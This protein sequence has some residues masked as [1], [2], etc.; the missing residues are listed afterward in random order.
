MKK[1]LL[2][3]GFFSF[4]GFQL[5][6]QNDTVRLSF[7]QAVN[8][9]QSRNLRL[10][11]AEAQIQSHEF[12]RK[13]TRGLYLP[14]ISFSATYMKFDQDIGLD[15]SPLTDAYRDAFLIPASQMLPSTL[16]L[17]KE[18]MAAASVNLIWPVFN[19]GKIRA[20]NQAMD[21]NINESLYI[22]EQAKN[23]LNTE[24][25]ERYYGYR[26]AQKGVE[27]YKEVYNAMLLHREN[28]VKL[29]ENG[30]ISKAQ[31]LYTEIALSQA[32]TDYQLA[33][34]QA[35]TVKK[36]LQ[37]T[38]A[39]SSEVIVTSELFLNKNIE[40][41]EFFQQSA[42]INNALL[43][44]V[45]AKKDLVKQNHNLKKADYYP[46][47]A[48]VA[49]KEIAEHQ[50]TELMPDWFIGVNL[51]WTIFDGIS[52][53]YKVKAAKATVDRVDFIE[54]KAEADIN[55]YI[56]KLYYDLLAYKEQLETMQTTYNFAVEYLRVEQKAFAEGFATTKD[57]VDA[58]TTL[59]KVKTGRLKVMNDYVLNLAKLLEFSGQP[60]LFLDY[61]QRVDRE[62]EKFID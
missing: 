43:K 57:V 38:I 11:S 33:L 26:M 41:L 3:I 27:L 17:Q 13:T 22:I 20:A 25:V 60:Q 31:R 29:E 30:M 24:L 39:D 35:K 4:L 16:V 34:N 51:R 18:E 2:T 5:F 23:E 15:I 49:N 40:S 42:I 8:Q 12:E 53:I 50:L 55:T 7:E 44:Q 61:S 52:R 46:A 59:S 6:A 45:R 19:G 54:A 36:A 32:K 1:I 58:Q 47:V 9:M 56:I 10:K 37:N 48:I 21:A 14:K 62:R 28:A